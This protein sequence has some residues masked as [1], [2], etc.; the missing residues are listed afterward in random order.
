M[1][2]LRKQT[3]VLFL[4]A[5]IG[6]APMLSADVYHYAG[7][8]ATGDQYDLYTIALTPGT[9]VVADL[10]CAP[11]P[12]NTLDTILTAY[13]PGVDSSDTG[14][15][16]FYDDDGG[17]QPCGGFNSSHLEFQVEQGGDWQ[18]RVDG[19]GSAIGDYTLDIS[20]EYRGVLAIPTLDTVGLGALVLLLGGAALFV[21]R[22]QRRA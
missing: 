2:R 18:F 4:F 13:A 14:N 22:R 20:T 17:S 21:F 11:P 9:F 15:S 1:K 8:I 7:T 12:D 10:V 3:M 6:F 16:T 5:V 19:F